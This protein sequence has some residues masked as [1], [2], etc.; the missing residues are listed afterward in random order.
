MHVRHHRLDA[1]SIGNA[2]A[3]TSFHYGEMPSDGDGQKIYIQSALHADEPPGMLVCWYLRQKLAALEASGRL[4]GEIV[5]V[6]VANPI[7]ASQYLLGT[8]HGRF[9]ASSGE[10]FNRHYADLM[11]SVAKAVV[12][13]LS[14]NSSGNKK[15][16]RQA[17]R[18]AID[19]QRPTTELHSLRLTLQ[20]LASE[21]DLVLDLHCDNE[22]IMHLYTGTPVWEEVEPF[23]RYIGA[24]VV[25]LA[26]E[27][28]DTPFDEA[29][30]PIWWKLRE[31]FGAAAPIPNGTVAVTVELRGETDVDH[32]SATHDAQAILNFLQH[33]GAI[34]GPVPSLP[35]SRYMAAPLNGMAPLVAPASG[36]VVHR[37][38]L[39]DRILVGDTVAD[40]IDPQTDESTPL[41]SPVDGILFARRQ[42]RIAT[43]GAVVARVAGS[44]PFRKGRLLTA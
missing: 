27:S 39:G 12:N 11:P 4:R 19:E 40:I 2:R 16:I 18:D 26:T 13:R 29:V 17:I 10:N 33:R 3:V 43:A 5:V 37:K 21:A 41:I 1:Q 44:L 30:A 42:V 24:H 7:G 9:E 28:G 32:A 6:P 14:E 15:L 23:A 22:G 31:R 8:P 20:R 25:L 38:S 34:A 35:A 36:V